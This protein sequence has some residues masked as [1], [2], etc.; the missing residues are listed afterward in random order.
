MLKRVITGA[1]IFVLMCVGII[2]Q[3]W[4]LRLMLLAAMLTSM[5]EMYRAL[6]AK[7]ARP[8]AWTGYVYCVLAVGLQALRAAY[9]A[10]LNAWPVTLAGRILALDT[11]SAPTTALVIGL[12]MGLS[13]IVARGKVA[14]D[15]L[16]AT[17]L[18]MLY[19]G[20]LF[21]LI[22]TLQDLPSPALATAALML[23]FFLASV[24]DVFALFTGMALGRRKLSPEI[25]PKK[26]VEGSI[27]G[28]AASVLFSV[29]IAWVMNEGFLCGLG[30]VFAQKTSFPLTAFAALGL[31]AG[32]LSQI[33]DLTASMVKRYCGVKDFGTIFPGHGGMMD[34]FDGIL[35][36]AAVVWVFF[37]LARF[38]AL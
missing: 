22:A 29:L 35:F 2:C 9:D 30:G 4:V 38:S 34:R 15:D 36:G 3:G 13:A 10:G 14:Y 17:V 27:G 25:S 20:L 18:P 11:L 24:N 23:S 12:L 33:G 5:F 28:L 37:H 8:G 19:P 26:T 32:A 21:S 1:G 7:G 6:R 16:S 31:I